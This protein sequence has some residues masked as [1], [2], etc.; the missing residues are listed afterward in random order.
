MHQDAIDAE[1]KD[2]LPPPNVFAHLLR[3]NILSLNSSGKIKEQLNMKNGD[4]FSCQGAICETWRQ[5]TGNGEWQQNGDFR[6]KTIT[7][8]LAY[9]SLNAPHTVVS[10]FINVK[11]I[12]CKFTNFLNNFNNNDIKELVTFLCKL[13]DYPT[14][15]TQNIP[16]EN[17][18]A[19]S[20]MADLIVDGNRVG[21]KRDVVNAATIQEATDMFALKNPQYK[22][23]TIIFNGTKV[24]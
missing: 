24:F 1:Y 14:Y 5:I 4:C 12:H 16:T 20:I 13:D 22:I 23:A 19:W 7:G 3:N 11:N 18:Y 15:K 8:G 9:A 21:F 17:I 6:Y 2:Y 10:F